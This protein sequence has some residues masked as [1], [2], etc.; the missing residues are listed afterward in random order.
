[1]HGSLTSMNPLADI[2]SAFFRIKWYMN[3][4]WA[5]CK[6][7]W[8]MTL[9]Y[10]AES[11][12]WFVIEL[13]PIIPMLSLW[14]YL[15][16]TGRMSESSAGELS[17]YYILSLIISRIF[18]I[19]FEDW[20]IEDIKDGTISKNLLKPFSYRVYLLANELTWRFA[21]L[22]YLLPTLLILLPVVINLKGI[23]TTFEAL[24]LALIILVISFFQKFMVSWLISLTAFWV[25]Q[26]KFLIHLKWML[27]G[28]AGGA[29][30]P[31]SFFPIWWQNIA[32]ATPFYSWFYFPI[33]LILRKVTI[34]EMVFGFGSAILWLLILLVIGNWFWKKS[35]I[36]YSSVG[37]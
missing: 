24:S 8:Q 14:N 29:W 21:G 27:E 12:V 36:R 11:L 4:F 10:R 16:M 3:K 9:S 34:P 25:D 19:H 6:M 37:G 22:I 18:S 15:R 31:L 26:S 2:L 20:V 30:L 28:I 5:F 35:I 33:Q 32:K 7:A 13:L 1:M 17:F 23:S